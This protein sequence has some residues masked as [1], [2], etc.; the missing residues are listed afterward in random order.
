MTKAINALIIAMLIITGCVHEADHNHQVK[1]PESISNQPDHTD[2]ESHTLFTENLE[3]FVEFDPLVTGEISTF[4][5]HLTQLRKE[6]SPLENAEVNLKLE[7]DQVHTQKFESHADIPG[8]YHFE[9]SPDFSG[10]GTIKIDVITDDFTDQFVIADVH[11]FKEAADIHS[12]STEAASG[13]V[14]YTKEQAWATGFNVEPVT[15]QDFSEVI[16]ASGEILAMPGE[17]QNLI[18][19]NNGI[20]L[21]STRN[22]VQGSPVKKGDLL[23]TVSGKGFTEDNISVKYHEARLQFEKSKNQYLRHKNLVEEKIVSE[24]QFAESKNRYLADS[25]IYFN[26]EQTVS[27]GG[28]KVFAPLTGY[29]HELNVSEGQFAATGSVLATISS[30]KIMLLRADVS[31]QHFKTLGQ[32]N[33]ATFRP[34]YSEKVYTI[35]ELNGKLLAKASSVAENNHYMPVY[36][37]VINDGTLLEG[38]FAE[39]HLKT[40]PKPNILVVPVSAIVEEQNNFFVYVQVSGEHFVKRQFRP[41]D[42]DGL[43]LEVISGLNEGD[44]IVTKGAM[45]IKAA[46]VSTAPVQSHSH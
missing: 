28:L 46:S 30:N 2:Q 8:I 19:K 6:Y 45:L 3:L 36:F 29:I 34:A 37:E 20:V 26:L 24:S 41:G 35:E 4:N 9:V 44:R 7:I 39:F 12:H 32:I 13:Q 21:F 5:V 22:L 15:F 38:A 16:N 11:I 43:F 27:D 17:K 1:K 18:A 31:Q 40:E 14:L 25:V 23:F 42:S 10:N 33:D